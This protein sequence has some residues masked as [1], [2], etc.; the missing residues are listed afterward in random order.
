MAINKHIVRTAEQIFKD[1]VKEA[2]G[3]FETLAEL[4]LPEEFLEHYTV[5]QL[6]NMLVSA[7]MFEMDWRFKPMLPEE[8]RRHNYD[9][10]TKEF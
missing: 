5:N 8:L 6:A 4:D 2:D 9:V 3:L 7:V 10:L 1:Q